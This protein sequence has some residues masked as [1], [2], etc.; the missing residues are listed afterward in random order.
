M[1]EVS[2]VAAAML[3]TS[4]TVATSVAVFYDGEPVVDDVPIVD[5]ALE[6]DGTAAIPGTLSLT[7]PRY[8]VVDDAE[9]D[10]L[11]T[12]AG[13]PLGSDG[14]QLAV[15]YLID[16]PGMEREAVA[17]GWYRVEEWAEADAGTIAVTAASLEALLAEARLLSAVKIAKTTPYATAATTLVGKLL[18]LEVTADPAQV[19]NAQVFEEERLDA[20]STLVTAWPARKYVDDE[21]T[22]QIGPPFDDATDPIVFAL[23]DGEEGTVVSA[24]RSGKRGIPN[25]VKA[26]GE[27]QGDVAPVSAVAYVHTGPRRWNGPYGNVPHFYTSSLLTTQAQCLSAAQRILR[28]LQWQAEEYTVTCA[29][30]PRIQYGD[31]GTLTYAGR[32]FPVRVTKVGLPLTADGGPMT[33]VATEVDR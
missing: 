25:A 12:A 13:S 33:L 11:P 1:R 14:H 27:S 22:L 8:I 21:G 18:P 4:H 17:L 29:P 5:G 2:P 15:T 23:T 19:T 10:L 7:L 26:S 20:L 9:V 16:L 24:P 6:Y 3:A 32:T 31:V 30:D 28:R